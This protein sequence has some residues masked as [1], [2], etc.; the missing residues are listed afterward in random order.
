MKFISVSKQIQIPYIN[1]VRNSLFSGVTLRSENTKVT[2][3][4]KHGKMNNQLTTNVKITIL[5]RIPR[6][7]ISQGRTGVILL[8]VAMMIV[9][10]MTMGSFLAEDC[11][12]RLW[13][14]NM[15]SSG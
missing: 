15:V 8:K 13:L 10:L 12:S 4:H 14:E 7:A 9:M 5:T 2:H 11:F 6:N 3:R 1:S